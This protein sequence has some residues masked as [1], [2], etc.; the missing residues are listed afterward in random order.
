M[1]YTGVISRCAKGK[2][3][4]LSVVFLTRIK[5]EVEYIK[6]GSTLLNHQQNVTQHVIFK[7]LRLHLFCMKKVI[8]V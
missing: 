2:S 3:F 7:C 1:D 4:F 5:M 8:S 6:T